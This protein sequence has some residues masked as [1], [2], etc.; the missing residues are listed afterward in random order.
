MTEIIDTTILKPTIRADGQKRRKHSVVDTALNTQTIRYFTNE[1][2]IEHDAMGAAWETGRP[3]REAQAEL[4]RLDANL[5]RP[6]EE[7]IEATDTE[8]RI[9]PFLRDV[10]ARKR[11][12]RAIIRGTGDGKLLS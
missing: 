10:L 8:P 9:S 1:E 3:V 7:Q 12:A 2:E 6:T 4:S 5:S 11:A